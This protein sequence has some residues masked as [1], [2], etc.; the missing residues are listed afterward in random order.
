VKTDRNYIEKKS[1]LLILKLYGKAMAVYG[2]GGNGTSFAAT[3]VEF[4]IGGV[5]GWGES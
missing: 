4:V 5:Y 2:F 3:I 1:K